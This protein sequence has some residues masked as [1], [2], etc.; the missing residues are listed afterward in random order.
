MRL[1]RRLLAIA[2]LALAP[3][4]AAYADE[5]TN[6]YLHSKSGEKIGFRFA[7]NTHIKFNRSN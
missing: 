6:L 7:Y 2:A 5:C 3:A 4:Y 1:L